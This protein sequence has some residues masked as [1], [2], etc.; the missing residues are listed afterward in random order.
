MKADKHE[1]WE[2]LK[3]DLELSTAGDEE[4]V[5]RYYELQTASTEFGMVKNGMRFPSRV[6]IVSS[7]YSLSKVV[8]PARANLAREERTIQTYKR[9]KFFGVRTREEIRNLLHPGP[10]QHPRNP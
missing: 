2:N 7:L 5:V 6:E 4:L 1:N 10:T 8:P 3:R 9:Y